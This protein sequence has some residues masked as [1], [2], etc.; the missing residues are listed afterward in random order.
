MDGTV[1]PQRRY[2]QKD[3]R[4]LLALWD[5]RWRVLLMNLRLN[6][7]KIHSWIFVKEIVKRL[8]I[9]DITVNMNNFNF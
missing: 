5:G 6:R 3:M 1:D 8:C 4:L 9:H 7:L 2:I